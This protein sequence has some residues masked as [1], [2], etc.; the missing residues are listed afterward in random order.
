M[1]KRRQMDIKAEVKEKIVEM[2]KDGIDLTS[3]EVFK[4]DG[5]TL[6]I[7]TYPIGEDGET[8]IEVFGEINI[9]CK[10]WYATAKTPAYNPADKEDDY[11]FIVAERERKAKEVAEKKAKKIAKQNK[12][13][14]KAEEKAEG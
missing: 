11:K 4:T 13:K 2:I 12:A 9:T 7:P 8:E 6:A 3:D 10:N 14:E 1:A 5:Y